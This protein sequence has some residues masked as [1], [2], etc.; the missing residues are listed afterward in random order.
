MFLLV[1]LSAIAFI[2]LGYFL[3]NKVDR[4]IE[5]E[6]FRINDIYDEY[7]DCNGAYENVILI[8]GKNDLSNLVTALCNSKGYRYIAMAESNNI[9]RELKYSCLLVLSHSDADNL[10]LSSIGLKV[11]SIPKVVALCNDQNYWKMY[12]EFKLHRILLQEEGNHKLLKDIEEL[13]EEAAEVFD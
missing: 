12:K 8:Y 9:N 13:L 4:F 3:M 5:S 2:L 1:L 7:R 6:D 11:Y 10:M